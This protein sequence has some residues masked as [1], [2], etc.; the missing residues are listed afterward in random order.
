MR[1][2]RVGWL[3]LT[4]LL[5]LGVRSQGFNKRYDAFGQGYAQGSY[6]IERAGEGWLV[7]SGSYEPDTITLDSLI[8]THSIVIN[9]IDQQGTL[10]WQQRYRYAFHASFQGWAD[11]CDTVPGDGF[12]VGGGSKSYTNVDEARLVRFNAQ[13][14]SLWS[15]TFGGAGEYWIGQQVKCLADGGFIVCGGTDHTGDQDGFLIRTD[16]GGNELWRQTYGWSNPVYIDG[17]TAVS[18]ASD[19][20]LFMSG[21]RF[22]SDADDQRWVQRTYPNGDLRWR[23]SWGGPYKEGATYLQLLEDGYPLIAGGYGNE[24]EYE[25]MQPYLAKLDTADGSILWEHKYGTA[26]WST[27]FFAAKECAN[28]DIIACGVS[29]EGGW[30]QGLLLRVTSTGDS[31]WMRRYASFDDQLDSCEGRFWDVLPTVDGGFIASGF[32]NLPYDFPFPPGTSQ[33]AWVVKVDSMG[34]IV[35]GC[36]ATGVTEVI[37]NL[38][39]ALRVWPNPAH[40]EV[41]VE[42]KLPPGLRDEDV[43]LSIISAEGRVVRRVPW[44]QANILVLVVQDLAPGMYTLHITDGTRWITGTKLIVE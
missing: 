2:L 24:P 8:A 14:D 5:S 22:L 13:G 35:P 16:A 20:D 34:C 36:D 28:T 32:G 38:K 4:A 19:G 43:D 27:L 23:V 42:L 26:V 18:E 21:S 7:I 37:T 25:H 3:W 17:L 40:G 39:D 9:R 10:L 29:Y 31:L 1:T 41:Q 44:Q 15:R 33:D 12:V 11:C 30:E 6:G